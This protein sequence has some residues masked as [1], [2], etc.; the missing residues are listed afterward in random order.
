LNCGCSLHDD[1]V[2]VFEVNDDVSVA[3][4]ID[5]VEVVVVDTPLFL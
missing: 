5:G 3:D 2:V 4:N 1:F